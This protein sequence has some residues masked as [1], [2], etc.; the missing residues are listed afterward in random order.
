MTSQK[1]DLDSNPASDS[2]AESVTAETP[3]SQTH[4]KFPFARPGSN[5]PAAAEKPWQAKG[6]N[7]R[8]E[9]KIGMPPK[10]TRRSMGKR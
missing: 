1:D 7:P 10:G 9:K 8:H 6:I 2:L 4:F 5:T 3:A